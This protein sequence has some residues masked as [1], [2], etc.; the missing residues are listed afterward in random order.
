MRLKKDAW[1]SSCAMARSSYLDHRGYLFGVHLRPCTWPAR[2]AHQDQASLGQS[3]VVLLLLFV[4][5]Y[6][7][8]LA[9]WRLCLLKCI[10]GYSHFCM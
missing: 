2:P 1:Y 3:Q 7:T 10:G 6:Q 9:L 4:N 5:M 8:D